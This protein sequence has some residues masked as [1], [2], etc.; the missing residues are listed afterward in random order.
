MKN[1][2]NARIILKNKTVK[3][4]RGTQPKA[5]KPGSELRLFGY[6]NAEID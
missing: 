1:K 2:N 5:T 4:S 3:Q 6:K